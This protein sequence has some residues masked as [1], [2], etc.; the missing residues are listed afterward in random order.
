MEYRHESSLPCSQLLAVEPCPETLQSQY[1]ISLR[2]TL[3]L[4]SELC[5]G[6][7]CPH[8]DSGFPNVSTC[9]V[10]ILSMHYLCLTALFIFDMI[11]V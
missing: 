10:L 3:I 5:L 7:S 6:L 8:F 4:S 9:A 1:F 11:I 2:Q